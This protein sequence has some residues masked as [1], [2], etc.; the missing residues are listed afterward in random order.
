MAE[1]EKF[2]LA[3]AMTVAINI[4]LVGLHFWYSGDW[5]P[6]ATVLVFYITVFMRVRFARQT[7]PM[8][9]IAT[10]TETSATSLS[11]S[12]SESPKGAWSSV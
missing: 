10:S 11:C 2:V 7:R 3:S 8:E 5:R 4:A 9:P 12:G 6:F 1:E